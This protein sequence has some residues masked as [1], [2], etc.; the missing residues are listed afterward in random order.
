MT[1]SSPRKRQKKDLERELGRLQ[2]ELVK[3]QECVRLEGRK[4]VVLFEGRDAA[5][6]G[7][8]IKRIT[9]SAQPPRSARGASRSARR[10]SARRPS[11]TS[12]ATSRTCRR[13]AR[14]CCST[15][16]GTTGPASSGSWASAPTTSTRSSCARAP[17]SSAC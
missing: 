4:V 13:P 12:S 17:S 1:D 3:L 10:P 8:A 7:G 6:K 9:E 16:A 2:V 15:A 5:G 14:S 11:G